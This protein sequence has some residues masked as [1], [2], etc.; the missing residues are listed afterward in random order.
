M[1]SG[2]YINPLV[3][4]DSAAFLREGADSGTRIAV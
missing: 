3:P 2:M 1:G 4:E